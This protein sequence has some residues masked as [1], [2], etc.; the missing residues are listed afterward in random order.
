[1]ADPVT[2]AALGTY[3]ATAAT[4]AS[5]GIGAATGIAGASASKQQA[6]MQSEIADRRAN[7]ERVAG[8]QAA[9]EEKRK[10]DLAQSRLGAVAGASG[11]GASD[12]TVMDIWGDI[13][14]KGDVNAGRAMASAQS[15]ADSI[16][17]QA[18]VDRWTADSNARLAKVGA[19]GT[20]IGG[21]GRAAGTYMD[22]TAR[23]GKMSAGSTGYDDMDLPPMA[24]R[25]GGWQTSVYRTGYGR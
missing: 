25:Y 2:M 18:A 13:E 23:I 9:S 10:A 19:A 7:E 20:L 12:P 14:A 17:Y 11:S 4:V 16:T 3:A 24:R 8:Q 5:A 6:R 1:M 15:K 22:G 21:L